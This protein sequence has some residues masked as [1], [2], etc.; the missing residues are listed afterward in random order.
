MD[1]IDAVKGR[2][3]IRHFLNDPVHEEDIKQIIRIGMLAPSAGNKQDWR[4]KA[5]L[6]PDL[7]KR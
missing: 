3:S 7:K 4:V 2:R 5:I 6:N 1:F